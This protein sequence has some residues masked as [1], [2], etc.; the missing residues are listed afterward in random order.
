MGTSEMNPYFPS[1]E[2]EGFYTN[3]AL[4]AG[5]PKEEMTCSLFFSNGKVTGRGADS[6]GHFTWK[7]VFSTAHMTCQ[8][9]KFYRTH[10][11]SYEGQVDEN[12]IWDLWNMASSAAGG[13]HIW[14]KKKKQGQKIA[15]AKKVKHAKLAAK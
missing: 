9:T 13:F 6:I 8:M 12:G 11:V 15:V 14:P 4:H 5:K 7:G 3:S 2:W 10:Q 1:G